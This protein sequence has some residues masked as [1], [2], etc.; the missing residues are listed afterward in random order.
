MAIR[1]R[2]RLT[3]RSGFAWRVGAGRHQSV[4][5]TPPR[6]R[7]PAI[8]S[9]RRILTKPGI[10]SSQAKSIWRAPSHERSQGHALS[11]PWRNSA[12]QA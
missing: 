8:H 9:D 1:E 11:W 12:Q 10:G 3:A 4:P 7:V 6:L 2:E 5:A